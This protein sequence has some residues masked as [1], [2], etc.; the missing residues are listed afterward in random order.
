MKPAVF[1]KEKEVIII[2][3]TK[4]P[5]CFGE[6]LSYCIGPLA[7]EANVDSM[8]FTNQLKVRFNA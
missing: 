5:F 2:I 6:R 4:L 8:K 7:S 1:T 3:I